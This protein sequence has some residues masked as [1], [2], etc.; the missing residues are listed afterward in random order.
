[1]TERQDTNNF[2][3]GSL[4]N[5]FLIAMPGM[6]DPTFAHS[7]TYICEHSDDGAMGLIINLPMELSLGDIYEQLELAT[8]HDSAHLPALAGGP[9]SVERGFVLHPAEDGRQWQSTLKV[10]PEIYLTASKDI[11][12]AMSRGEGPSH[13]LVALGYAGWD[14]GQLEQEIADNAWLTVAADQQILFHTPA[15]QRWAAAAKDLGIDLNLIS[16][17]AGHA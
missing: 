2:E 7:V 12:E 16:N 15:E 10:S 9:V 13:Y 14:Q 6:S 17:T 1:M 4:R 3:L 8:D 11:L 5:Q